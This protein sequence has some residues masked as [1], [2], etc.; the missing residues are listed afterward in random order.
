MTTAT[1]QRRT[2][3]GLFADKPIPRLYDRIVDVL[4]VRHDS[5]RTE[6]AYLHWIRR[7]VEFHGHQRPRHLAEADVHRFLTRL[8]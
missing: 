6:A 3:L 8:V 1:E 7:Y 4:R 5:R 2:H